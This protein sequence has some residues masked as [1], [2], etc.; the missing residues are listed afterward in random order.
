MSSEIMPAIVLVADSMPLRGAGIA[1]LVGQWVSAL[2]Q[3]AVAVEAG[4][5][6]AYEHAGKVSLIVANVGSASL[7]EPGTR[8]LMQGILAAFPSTPCAILSDRSESD[9]AIDAAGLGAAA[10]ITM[11]TP[12]DI[13]QQALAFVIHGGVYFPRQ[14]LVDSPAV[15]PRRRTVISVQGNFL[16]QRQKE[17]LDCLKRGKPN[18]VIA[19]EL[20]MQESTVKVHVRQIM[21]RL[22]AANRTQ[23]VIMSMASAKMSTDN[24]MAEAS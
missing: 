8:V 17:V 15:G 2:G 5:M 1:T 10:F 16:T 20:D 22:G 21:R 23:V 6:E 13:V 19:R 9:E 3:T 24:G 7:R 14:A 18:K 4:K 11:T 12:L